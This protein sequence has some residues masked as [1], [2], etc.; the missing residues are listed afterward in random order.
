MPSLKRSTTRKV[1]R[2]GSDPSERLV[3]E[4]IA[5]LFEIKGEEYREKHPEFLTPSVDEFFSYARQVS[6]ALEKTRIR[7][8]GGVR[9]KLP[10]RKHGG[11]ASLEPFLSFIIHEPVDVMNP[12]ATILKLFNIFLYA[13]LVYK[14]VEIYAREHRANPRW[15]IASIVA[16]I[17]VVVSDPGFINS[18]SDPIRWF[19]AKVVP[20]L[21]T[22]RDSLQAGTASIV[23]YAASI[24]IP[25]VLVQRFAAHA[26]TVAWAVGKAVASVLNLLYT[27][28]FISN[29]LL[30][31]PVLCA[32]A[33]AGFEECRG[34]CDALLEGL[35]I[36]RI[37]S[38]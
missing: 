33:A 1:V 6:D 19:C 14:I 18:F 27:S 25:H 34:L 5:F 7:K 30:Y 37:T 8:K 3:R 20:V 31:M 26:E 38:S 35:K 13:V 36:K 32:M 28:P 17:Q 12:C 23:E 29:T 21:N 10:M 4:A 15:D 2:G 22:V 9:R 24:I 16:K 11:G